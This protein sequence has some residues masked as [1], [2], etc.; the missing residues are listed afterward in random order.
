VARYDKIHLY[1][2]DLGTEVHKESATTEYGDKIV[3]I[4]TPFGKIGLTVCY[5]IRFGSLFNALYRQHVD[6]ITIPAAFTIPTG[7]AHWEALMRARAI[8]GFCYTIGACQTGT[9]SSGR[10]TYGHS[11]IV[12]PWGNI[13]SQLPDS[14]GVITVDID[15]AKIQEI[16]RKIPVHQH[17]RI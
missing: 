7:E 12:G 8:E 9:H 5:D 16:R 10:K 14:E 11:L 15:L 4:D 6:I 13:E 2:V 3:T 17:Q 1:D